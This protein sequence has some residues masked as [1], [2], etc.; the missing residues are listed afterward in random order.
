MVKAFID[1]MGGRIEVV[2]RP[3]E[4]TRFV[5][6][7]RAAVEPPSPATVQAVTPGTRRR[8]RVL[9]VEDD[10]LL[11][12]IGQSMLKTQGHTVLACGQAQDAIDR[13][14]AGES[15]DILFTDVMMPGGIN[16]YELATTVKQLCPQMAVVLASGWTN[17]KLAADTANLHFATFMQ[18][19]YS[20]ADLDKAFDAALNQVNDAN[21]K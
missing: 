11:R 19:P 3:D 14:R 7:L 6:S 21:K 20:M 8:C 4:G 2:S 16:G 12:L 17:I 9:M 18:K 15:F 5:I 1:Q 10:D 13:L